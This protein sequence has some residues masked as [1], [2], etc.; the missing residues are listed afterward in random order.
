MTILIRFR[1]AFVVCAAVALTL[2]AGPAFAHAK[3]LSEVPAAEDAAG[4]GVVGTEPVTELRLSFS[5]ELNA[6]FSK[7][8]VTD[9]AGAAVAGA[10]VA[11]DPSDAKVMVVTFA[12]PLPT[13]EYAV[14]WT[15]VASDGHKTT[16]TYKVNVAQ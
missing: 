9:A 15:A 13:G 3:L 6:A 10:T 11:L 2:A 8:S 1:S 16:G 5:E 12:A 14:D 7:V 4:A